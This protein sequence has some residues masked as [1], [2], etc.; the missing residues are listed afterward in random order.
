MRLRVPTRFLVPAICAALT[1]AGGG[2]WA[3]PETLTASQAVLHKGTAVPV[4][5]ETSLRAGRD[6]AGE[7]VRFTVDQN[8]YGPGHALLIEKGAEAQGKVTAS[9]EHGSFGRPSRLTFT[10]DS[11]RAADGAEIPLALTVTAG[12]DSGPAADAASRSEAQE[13]HAFTPTPF[14]PNGYVQSSAPGG[15]YY[16]QT[17]VSASIIYDPARF[18][19]SSEDVTVK[20]GQEYRATVAADTPFPSAA[21]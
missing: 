6:K 14:D 9:A 13:F 15:Y 19:G 2:L 7:I 20:P 8:V 16:Q 5:L 10:C 1:T 18:F 3:A 12:A 4:R 11:V 21:L 17:G